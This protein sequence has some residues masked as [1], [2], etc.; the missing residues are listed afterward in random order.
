MFYYIVTPRCFYDEARESMEKAGGTRDCSKR[1]CHPFVISYVYIAT[2][3][4]HDGCG[5]PLAFRHGH[6]FRLPQR[7]IQRNPC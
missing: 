5:I 7:L 3:Q 2:G 1:K 4:E 6:L